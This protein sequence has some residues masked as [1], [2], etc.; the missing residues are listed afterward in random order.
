MY[1]E[2]RGSPGGAVRGWALRWLVRSVALLLALAVLVAYRGGIRRS[3]HAA[4]EIGRYGLR[5]PGHSRVAWAVAEPE[6]EGLSRAALDSL[7][8]SLAA[9]GTAALVVVRGNHVVYEWYG[10]KSGP[11]VPYI[12]TAMAKAV[13][14]TIT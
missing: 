12:T 10:P 7:R 4:A 13:T 9:E 3:F 6:Q 2:N 8:S 14:G 1:D 11:D 5:R